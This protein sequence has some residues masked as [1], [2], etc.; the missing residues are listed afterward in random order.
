MAAP[1]VAVVEQKQELKEVIKYVVSRSIQYVVIV[2]AAEAVCD[3]PYCQ[4]RAGLGAETTRNPDCAKRACCSTPA[5]WC[6]PVVEPQRTCQLDAQVGALEALLL[7]LAPGPEGKERPALTPPGGPLG[8]SEC[9]PRQPGDS[10][11]VGLSAVDPNEAAGVAFVE[12]GKV[13]DGKGFV[14]EELSERQVVNTT[15]IM[16]G[17][18]FLRGSIARL[19]G[20]VLLTRGRQAGV[21]VLPW[22]T[23]RSFVV[24]AV[25][26]TM[27][28]SKS[29]AGSHQML[30]GFCTVEAAVAALNAGQCRSLA[31]L[32]FCIL[33]D[34]RSG[35][36]IILYCTGMLLTAILYFGFLV[37]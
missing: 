23:S 15:D 20:G 25:A 11:G 37:L 29:I 26:F 8:D 35:K 34:P 18:A 28:I 19:D 32:Q 31:Q 6:P 24:P 13:I 27:D 33:R 14:D 3:E 7:S 12:V 9:P 30:R 5:S 4:V 36:L 22:S 21:D 17:S 10:H 16:L 2:V 1:S